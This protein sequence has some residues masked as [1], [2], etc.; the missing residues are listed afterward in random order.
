MRYPSGLMATVVQWRSRVRDSQ[1]SARKMRD[2][3]QG[4]QHQGGEDAGD[5]QAIGG[6][7]DG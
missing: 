5:A 2:A 1:D 7:Q 4:D 3:G 6:L